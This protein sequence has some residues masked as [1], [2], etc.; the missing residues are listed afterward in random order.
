VSELVHVETSERDGVVVASLSGEL[1]L[2]AADRVGDTIAEAVPTTASGL[3]VD[4]SE[5]TFIDSSGVAMLFSLA[6]R[7]SSRRQQL[8]CVTQPGS[9]VARVLEIVEFE[10]AGAIDADLERALAAIADRS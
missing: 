3:V 7:L 4:F 2:S 9:P 6:R 5:V 8:R 1:D 10:R